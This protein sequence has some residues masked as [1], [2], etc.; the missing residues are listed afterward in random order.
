MLKIDFF[1]KKKVNKKSTKNKLYEILSF[2]SYK[3]I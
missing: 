2:F 1:H 3:K